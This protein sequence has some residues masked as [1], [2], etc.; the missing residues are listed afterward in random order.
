MIPVSAEFPTHIMQCLPKAAEL[1][2]YI[3]YYL[4]KFS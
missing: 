3:L 2:V 4:V 1:S